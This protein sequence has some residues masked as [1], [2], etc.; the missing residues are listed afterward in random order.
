MKPQLACDWDETKVRFPVLISPKIDGVRAINLN[1]AVTGRSLKQHKNK[2][3]TELLSDSTTIGFDGEIAAESDTHPALCRLTSSALSTI[4]GQPFVLWWLFDFVRPEWVHRPYA[5]RYDELVSRVNYLRANSHFFS[6]A[7]HL[8]VVPSVEVLCME[9]LL[10][11]EKL[12]LDEGYEGL[13]GRDPQGK[14]KHGRSTVR[15]GGLWRIKRFSDA[16]AVVKAIKEGQTN[17]NETTVNELGKTE[18][19]THTENMVPNGQ[20]GTL[21]CVTP[22]GLEIN[23]SPGEMDVDTR[24]LYFSNP[25]MIVG[26]TI[27]YKHFPKGRKDLPR[28][29][30]FKC[31]REDL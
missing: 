12:W 8:R 2:Y 27:T 25:S 18:R 10:H 20:V 7:H 21:I 1:G 24:K 23:V 6:F 13:I 17:L 3:V 16:E 22:E 11:W 31:I 14:V 30:T 5:E 26:K 29:P 15:E 9:E 19:S 4:E 28:F